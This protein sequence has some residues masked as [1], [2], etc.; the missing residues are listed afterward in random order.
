MSSTNL[1]YKLAEEYPELLLVGP[2]PT[3]KNSIGKK[4]LYL[5]IEFDAKNGSAEVSIWNDNSF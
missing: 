1:S 4:N 3:S 2:L 5:G